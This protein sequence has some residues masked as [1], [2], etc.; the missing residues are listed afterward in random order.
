M[1]S[2]DVLFSFQFV[3]KSYGNAEKISE[4]TWLEI[5]HLFPSVEG[6][7]PS[8]MPH[9]QLSFRQNRG[10]FAGWSIKLMVCRLGP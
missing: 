2:P 9:S 5:I 8:V 7:W 10:R 3:K 1:S 4:S 6:L